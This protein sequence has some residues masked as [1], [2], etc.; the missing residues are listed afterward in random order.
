M[1]QHPEFA[2]GLLSSID[3]LRPAKDIPCYHHERW[4]GSGYP[5]G[6]KKEE[7]P[8]PA[9]LFA[10]V[11]VFDALTSDRPYRSKWSKQAALHYIQEQAGILFDPVIVPIFL[12][13]I[14]EK[15]HVVN[16]EQGCDSL[17]S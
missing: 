3:Y 1:R 15:Q 10:I 13:M 7:I 17:V 11:D 9:R 5:A 12:E 6:L 16:I 14:K 2:C 8:L 4:N